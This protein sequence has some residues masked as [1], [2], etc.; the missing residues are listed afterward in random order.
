MRDQYIR[1][2]QGFIIVYSI[3]SRPSFE[4]LSTFHDQILRVK[5]EDTFP[6]VILGNKCDLEKDRE[7]AMAEA[8]QFAES[9]EAPFYETSAKAR[10][11]VE[12]G[13]Y[14]LVR[15]IRRWNA[16]AAQE[17]DDGKKKKKK[18]TRCI[19]L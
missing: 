17:D 3:T 16:M 12:E 14:Q 9:I 8:K 19:I 10:I 6:V 15:E 2:G 13:F 5:D 4:N 18:R 7:V 1:S 11:N